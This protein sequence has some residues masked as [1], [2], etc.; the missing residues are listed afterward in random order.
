MGHAKRDGTVPQVDSLMV[1]VAHDCTVYIG[2][3]L[4]LYKDETSKSLLVLVPVRLGGEALNSIYIP[5]VKVR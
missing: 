4:D 5:C 1:Y 2:D 3:V